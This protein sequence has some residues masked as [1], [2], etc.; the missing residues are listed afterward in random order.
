MPNPRT[1]SHKMT[2][3]EVVSIVRKLKK[4][5]ATALIIN[6]R[7]QRR[8][9]MNLSDIQPVSGARTAIAR[10]VGTT[11]KPACSGSNLIPS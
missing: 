5:K 3:N 1:L 8:A 2:V 9:G 10:G 6:P 7:L 11:R 4:K